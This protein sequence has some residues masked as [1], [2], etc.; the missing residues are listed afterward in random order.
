MLDVRALAGG[1]SNI[2]HPTSRC[3]RPELA[4]GYGAGWMAFARILNLT[5]KGEAGIIPPLDSSDWFFPGGTDDV[6]SSA[7]PDARGRSG[8]CAR[9]G[10]VPEP[11]GPALHR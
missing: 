10:R 9:R 1:T 6:P 11:P 2:Q 8:R 5:G 7:H 4:A 3:R